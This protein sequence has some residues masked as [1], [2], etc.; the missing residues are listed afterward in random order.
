MSFAQPRTM[1]TISAAAGVPSPEFVGLTLLRSLSMCCSNHAALGQLHEHL[2]DRNWAIFSWARLR[3]L[4]P[5]HWFLGTTIK[6]GNRGR[7]PQLRCAVW[8]H[9]PGPCAYPLA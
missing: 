7:R 2:R 1:R 9:C 6:W 4:L 3:H 8:D 5:W